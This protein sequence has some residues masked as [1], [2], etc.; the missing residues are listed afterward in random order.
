MGWSQEQ[1]KQRQ[2]VLYVSSGHDLFPVPGQCHPLPLDGPFPMPLPWWRMWTGRWRM[3]CLLLAM[4]H[5][6]S[7]SMY[8]M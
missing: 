5:R 2:A 8:E 6:V 4:L 1:L 7:F 3:S